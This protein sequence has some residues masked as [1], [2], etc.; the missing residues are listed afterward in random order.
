MKHIA[1]IAALFGLVLSATAQNFGFSVYSSPGTA[2][3]AGT[4]Y[5]IIPP[6]SKTGGEPL[7]TY[8]N[9][10]CLFASGTATLTAY[11]S[12]NQTTANYTNS[13]TTVYVA[14]T[15]GFSAG[16]YVVIQHV[17]AGALPRFRNEAAQISSVAAT[18]IVLATAPT[19]TVVPGDIVNVEQSWAT[20][21]FASSATATSINGP[22][23]LS[24]QR[25]EPFLLILAGS[26]AGTNTI[27]AACATYQ[28]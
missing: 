15:N 23:I 21:P 4:N 28:P 14:S 5:T 27:N 19:S 13:T 7:V 8:L 26:A 24:G 18:N 25:S 10:N 9:A 22:G 1:L 12:T 2:L 20:I 6:D 3:N 16:S 11:V 17:V